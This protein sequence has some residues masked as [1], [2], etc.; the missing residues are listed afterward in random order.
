MRL[1]GALWAVAVAAGLWGCA[2]RSED[3]SSAPRLAVVI[4][5]DQLRADA[6]SGAQGRFE[7]GL[8]RLVREG[9]VFTHA[10]HD[11]APTVTA[12]GH[13]TLLSGRFPSSTGVVAN[14]W[15]D[16]RLGRQVNAVEDPGERGLDGSSGAS[17]R[18][19]RGTTLGDWLRQRFPS[20]RVASVARKDR[21]AVLMAGRSS[22]DVV[23]YSEG[24]GGF[25]TSTF[26]RS[27]LPGW[28]EGGRHAAARFAGASWDLLRGDATAYPGAD[29]DDSPWERGP[30]GFGRVFPHRLPSETIALD[31]LFPETPFADQAT[32]E[33]ALAA[34]AALDLGGDDIPDLLLV[35]LSACDAIGHDYGPDSLEQHDHLARVD[36]MIGQFLETLEQRV[37]RGRLLV[38]LSSDHGVAEIPERA[39]SRGRRAGRV[40]RSAILGAAREAAREAVGRDDVVRDLVSWQLVL[41]RPAIRA[42]GADPAAVAESVAAAV[43]KVPGVERA[44][45]TCRLTGEDGTRDDVTRRLRHGFDPDR[46][47]DVLLVLEPGFLLDSSDPTTHG[48]PWPTD[49]DVPL[50]LWGSGVHPGVVGRSVRAVDLAPTLAVL[51]GVPPTELL[52]GEPLAEAFATR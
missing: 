7:T 12:A 16:R 3:G 31:R 49:V 34:Q 51:L 38:A 24:T 5:V 52:D 32:L 37:G 29:A 42:A 48:S 44:L 14:E 1:K 2:A 8:G 13:A 11:H 17:P 43:A 50:I 33:L 45:T 20:S 4:V 18:R 25:T 35:G 19:L 41:D 26:Y 28:A 39:V 40:A 6:L 21:V 22:R 15:F 27:D 47:G 23:W 36:V 9:A 10:T 46:S 30:E